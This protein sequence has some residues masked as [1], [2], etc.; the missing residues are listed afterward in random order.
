LSKFYQFFFQIAITIVF[1][2]AIEKKITE[3]QKNRRK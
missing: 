1:L 2:Q 3:I